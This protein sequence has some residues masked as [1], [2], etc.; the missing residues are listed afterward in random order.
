MYTA[1]QHLHSYWA[2]LVLLVVVLAT[3]NAIIKFIGKKPF[4]AKDF[5]LSLFALI[6]MHLQLL[7]GLVLYFSSPYFS[8]FST[9]GMSE[10]MGDA[11]LR[12]YL[13]EHPTTMILA[14]VFITMGYSKHKKK[15]SSSKKFKTLTIFYS[16]ALFLLLLIIPW[17]AW[18]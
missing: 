5:R 11:T 2:Y 4:D 9:E 6:L 12:L 15:L 8:A 14:I 7:I 3:F 16:L 10:I 13:I 18:F 1:I 17:Q